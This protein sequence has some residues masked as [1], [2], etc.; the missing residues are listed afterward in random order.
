MRNEFRPRGLTFAF[1]IPAIMLSLGLAFPLVRP[2]TALAQELVDATGTHLHLKDH[3]ERIVALMPSLGELA[4]DFLGSEMGRLVGVSEY[5]DFPPSLIKINKVGPYH[6]LNLEAIAA[7]KPDLILGSRDGNSRDQI[8]HLR[9]LGMPVVV[10]NTNSFSKIEES[11]QMVGAAL[12]S[13]SEGKRA[14]DQFHRGLT[15]LQEKIRTGISPGSPKPRVL[16]QVGNDPLVTVGRGTFLGDALEFA[17][18]SNLY[19]DVS[20]PYPRPTLEDVIA[21]NPDVIIIV[22][23]SGNMSANVAR[24]ERITSEWNRFSSMKAV[25]HHRIHIISDDSLLRPTLRLLEGLSRLAKAIHY[26]NQPK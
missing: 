21:R 25:S 6:R 17:G 20:T 12:G 16:L 18:A 5:S 15:Q 19:G 3:P 4:A 9:E 22:D 7:L 24:I 10:V 13:A 23:M 26:K 11:M 8:D 14:A 1:C 2:T